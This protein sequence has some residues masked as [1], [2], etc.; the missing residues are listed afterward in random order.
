MNPANFDSLITD[1]CHAIY[2]SQYGYDRVTK[3]TYDSIGQV[4][5]IYKAYGTTLQQAYRTN[6]YDSSAIG[7]LSTI[8]DANNNTTRLEYD[9]WGRLKYRRYPN[10]SFNYYAYDGNGNME[11]ETKRNGA[12]I[13]Y[14][15]D[16]NNRLRFKDYVDNT[17]LDDVSY[18]YD[19]RGLTLETTAGSYSDKKWVTNTF[20]GVGNLLSTT[21]AKGYY[22]TTNVRT[23]AYQYDLNSNRERVTHPDGKYFQYNFD[24]LNRVEVLKNEQNTSLINVAYNSYGK[25]DSINRNN[26]TAATTHYDYDGIY[27]LGYLKQD[28]NYDSSDL[29]NSF[30]YNPANQVLTVDYANSIYAYNGN[31]NL[32]GNYQVNNLNQYTTVNGNSMSY[33]GNGNL[34]SDGASQAN[35]TYDIENRLLTVSGYN[36]TGSL[37]YDPLGRLYEAT[38]NGK[39]TQFL[40]DGDALVAEYNSTGIQTKRYVHGD[41]V[42]EPWLQFSGTDTGVSNAVFLHA[43][44]Q[45]SIVAHSD[46]TANSIHTLSYDAYGIAATANN[47][48][49]AY[50]GQIDFTGLGLY[51]YK[52]RIYHPKL[53]RFLQTDPVGYEDQ[54]NLYAYV[55][56][57]PVNMVDPSGEYLLSALFALV[58]VGVI[59]DNVT[60]SLSATEKS[61]KAEQDKS[62]CLIKG[63]AEACK[64]YKEDKNKAEKLKVKAYSEILDTA[65]SGC[66][67]S[68]SCGTGPATSNTEVGIAIITTVVETRNTSVTVTDLPPQEEIEK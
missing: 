5:V 26:N 68:R 20:D 57:D 9:G 37:V 52:A 30:F 48:R 59:W 19:L 66:A 16:N 56:N 23:L 60:D 31:L 63:D 64:R 2:S 61:N 1:A 24:G 35:Y 33:D 14:S 53:G 3:F 38:I 44:H 62:D 40:Y 13:N 34:T 8:K 41:Q 51:Y 32:T 21:T 50:T 18:T 22:P 25:R 46:G 49:F 29:T 42:D 36:G 43:D 39:V 58:T 4:L 65:K 28:F 54:M 12:V 11:T 10:T 17:T 55:G 6:T 15:Y 45:G 27:R 47:S 67:V 7:L